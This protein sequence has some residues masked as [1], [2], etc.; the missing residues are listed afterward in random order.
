MEKEDVQNIKDVL[1]TLVVAINDGSIISN[2]KDYI[3]MI[4]DEIQAHHTN[5]GMGGRT[6]SHK[7]DV[8]RGFKLH[9]SKYSDQYPHRVILTKANLLSFLPTIPIEGNKKKSGGNAE[10]CDPN[11]YRSRLHGSVVD[12]HKSKDRKLI[13]KGAQPLS[14]EW[15]AWEYQCK[16]VTPNSDE[17]LKEEENAMCR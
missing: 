16:G 1:I 14:P 15:P 9:A 5:K 4:E 7:I 8:S 12:C 2:E 10:N 11:Y 13:H 6:E 3:R 17:A